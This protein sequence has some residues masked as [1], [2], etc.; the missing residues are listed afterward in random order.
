LGS[1]CRDCERQKAGG[2]RRN[3]RYE[4]RHRV[5]KGIR[6]KLC[7]K[8]NRWKNETAFYKDGLAR[9]GLNGWCRK[10]VCEAARA[11]YKRRSAADD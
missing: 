6:Q 11:S 4:D 8:C 9:D 1:R 3:L 7:S 5:V 10:C 2:G